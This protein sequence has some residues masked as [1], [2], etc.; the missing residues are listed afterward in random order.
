MITFIFI[1]IQHVYKVHDSI[2]RAV[3]TTFV[4]IIHRNKYPS[5][6]GIE[7]GTSSDIVNCSHDAKNTINI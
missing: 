2:T 7:S 5:R 4:P 1:L 6:P 3:P